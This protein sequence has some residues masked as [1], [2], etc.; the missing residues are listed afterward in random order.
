ME[1]FRKFNEPII[2]AQKKLNNLKKLNFFKEYEDQGRTQ[3][4]KDSKKGS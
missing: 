4:Y 1:K 3:M 2:F